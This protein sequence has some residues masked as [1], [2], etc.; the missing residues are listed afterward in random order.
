[1]CFCSIGGI[2]M[3]YKRLIIEMIEKTE[4]EK[5]LRIIYLY[6]I[7]IT[8]EK[9]CSDRDKWLKSIFTMLI[10]IHDVKKI[11]HIHNMVQCIYLKNI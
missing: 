1:M 10:E 9:D 2:N 11:E 4:D 7:Y 8:K 5:I 3:N 6:M